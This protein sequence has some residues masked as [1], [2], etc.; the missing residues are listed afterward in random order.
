MRLNI[1]HTWAPK[2]GESAS[3][4]EDSFDHICLQNGTLMRAA[5]ADGATEAAYSNIWAQ[6]LVEHFTSCPPGEDLASTLR[7]IQEK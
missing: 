5:I 1:Q 3:D 6:K 7:K 4:Y 2:Q